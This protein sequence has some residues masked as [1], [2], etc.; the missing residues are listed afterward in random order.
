VEHAS[1]PATIETYTIMHGRGGAEYAAL[2]GRLAQTG[3]R[4][5][6]NT[7]DDPAVLADLQ[8]HEGLGRRGTVRPRD[9]RNVFVPD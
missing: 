7:P 4:F 1:G 5:V 6:A 9:G 2:L 8:D 3:E